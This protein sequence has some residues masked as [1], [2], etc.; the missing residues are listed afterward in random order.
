MPPPEAARADTK[1]SQARRIAVA[2]IQRSHHGPC[3]PTWPAIRQRWRNSAHSATVESSGW[4]TVSRPIRCSKCRR[5]KHPPGAKRPIAQLHQRLEGEQHRRRA[6]QF[7]VLT[8]QLL[9]TVVQ[10]PAND[11][12]V[13]D[14]A[15]LAGR[16][17][18]SARASWKRAHSSSV[19]SSLPSGPR[20]RGPQV[21]GAVALCATPPPA[22][23]P[24]RLARPQ[25][26]LR[27]R[28]QSTTGSAVLC[29]RPSRRRRRDQWRSAGPERRARPPLAG[30]CITH[31]PA[32]GRRC[33]ARPRNL[34]GIP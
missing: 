33:R 31:L 32:E 21:A 4:T 29:P 18:S 15:R 7:A 6:D 1:G 28:W 30:K 22:D 10:Q 34:W 13:H 26:L 24:P 8:G 19:R 14:D 11:H 20:P 3:R 12:G 5:P 23:T 25:A 16:P 2:A 9:G 17:H 27:I